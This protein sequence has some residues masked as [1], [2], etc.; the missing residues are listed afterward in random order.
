MIEGVDELDLRLE[1]KKLRDLL[2]DLA[3]AGII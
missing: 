1:G 3:A 2:G